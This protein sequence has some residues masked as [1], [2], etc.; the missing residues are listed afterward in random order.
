MSWL[1]DN[2]AAILGLIALAG[3]AIVLIVEFIKT[4]RASQIEKVKEWLLYAVIAA[5]KELGSGTG[6]IK[7]RYVYNMFL[8][9]FPHLANIISF[10]FFSDLVDEALTNMKELLE[11]N[12]KIEKFIQD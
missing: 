7:L 4:P 10:D 3:T 1:V 8:K 6:E 2:W 5:E 12:K 9:V 11:S